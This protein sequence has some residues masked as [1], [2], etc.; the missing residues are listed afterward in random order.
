MFR[1]L[2][3][4]LSLGVFIIVGSAGIW[5]YQEHFSA[6]RE[7]EQA[8]QENRVLQ[9]VVQRLSDEKRVAEVLVT[10]QK[11]VDGVLNTTLL[12]VEYD[13]QGN[14][15]P[16]RCFTVRG[17]RVHFDALVIKF[18]RDFVKQGD[19]LRG[20]SIALFT[21]VYGDAQSPENGSMI[22]TPG[23][24]PEIYRDTDPRLSE[25]EQ[26]LWREFWDLARDP[27]L[28]DERGVRVANGQGLWGPFEPDMLYTITLE[29]DG[30]L[31]MKSE[32]LKGIY[33]EA[34]KRRVAESH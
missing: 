10:D 13:R 9:Q 34:L 29:S 20:H 16:P 15:L 3:K 31:N 4:I 26:K 1:P 33:R 25:F 27:K 32:P 18:D 14:S 8:K 12:F 17:K 28:R 11:T 21:T 24:V 7:L 19:G 2:S 5:W 30:G 22:D 6:R 23:N